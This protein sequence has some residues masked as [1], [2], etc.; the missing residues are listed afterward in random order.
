M[1]SEPFRF[2]HESSLAQALEAIEEMHKEA[3]GLREEIIEFYAEEYARFLEWADQV[4]TEAALEPSKIESALRRYAQAYPT[5]EDLLKNCLRVLVEGPVKLP[6]LLE[7]ALRE[8]AQL[9]YSTAVPGK[10]SR[11]A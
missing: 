6:S 11:Y 10:T 3:D 2:V 5:K 1:L 9:A 4:L 7:E 8:S